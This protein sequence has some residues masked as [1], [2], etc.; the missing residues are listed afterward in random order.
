LW[1]FIYTRIAKIRLV[2]GNFGQFLYNF[3]L[4]TA[5]CIWVFSVDLL[6]S[7]FKFV[8]DA[9]TVIYGCWRL[10]KYK[11]PMTENDPE[12]FS[13][14]L[15]HIPNIPW[16]SLRQLNNRLI[17]KKDEVDFKQAQ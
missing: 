4:E 9:L 7:L 2:D 6:P 3:G 12:E 13:W 1:N 14:N 16:D 10:R 15:N 17:M 8:S 11:C 5:W